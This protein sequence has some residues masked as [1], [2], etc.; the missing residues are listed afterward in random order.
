MEHNGA[1]AKSKQN[2]LRYIEVDKNFIPVTFK[3]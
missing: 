2:G 3:K 1:Y